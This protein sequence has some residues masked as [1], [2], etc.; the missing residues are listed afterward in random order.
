MRYHLVSAPW[1]G[2]G[3]VEGSIFWQWPGALY[4]SN[5]QDGQGTWHFV[6]TRAQTQQSSK[7]DLPPTLN[8]PRLMRT[9]TAPYRDF[10]TLG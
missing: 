4:L 1:I 10:F 9:K 3:R 6:L 2:D 7:R 5:L 8:M